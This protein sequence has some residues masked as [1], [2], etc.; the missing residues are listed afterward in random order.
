M[1]D[2]TPPVRP[3]S[4]ES[5]DGTGSADHDLPYQ[6]GQRPTTAAPF[7]FSPLQL[8]RLLRLRGLILDQPD[9]DDS[10]AA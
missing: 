8:S 3:T 7:P 5:K 1:S 6:W 9:I 2:S 4:G 10:V